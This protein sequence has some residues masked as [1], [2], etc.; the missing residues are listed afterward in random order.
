VA[1]RPRSLA[2]ASLILLA[3]HA[4]GAADLVGAWRIHGSVFFN[5]VETVCRFKGDGP[6]VAATCENGKPSI[7]TPVTV[8]GGKVAW[9]WDAGPAVLVFQGALTSDT[10]IT[11]EIKVRGFTGSFTATKQ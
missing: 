1:L 9:N 11:G 2:L 6:G 8:T 7:F 5:A 10:T 3:S 4:A